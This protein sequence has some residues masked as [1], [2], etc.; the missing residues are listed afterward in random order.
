MEI[1]WLEAFVAVAEELHFGRAAAR[2][3]LAQSPLSQTIRKLEKELGTTLFDRSTRSVALTPAGH[4]FLPH[5]HRVFEELELARQAT[6][7]TDGVVYGT[8][9]IGFSGALNHLTL[10]PL[11]RAVRQRYPDVTLSLTGRVMTRDGVEALEQGGLDIAFVGLPIGPSR[12]RTR[13]IGREPLGAVLPIDHPLA[14]EAGI[15]LAGLAQDGF[16]TTPAEAGSALQELAM[17]ACVKAGFRPRIVQEITDPYMI[18]TLVS[19]GVG[20]ALMSS[21]ISGIL[22]SGAVF[23]PLRGEQT[24]LEHALAWLEDNPSPVLHAVLDVAAE[25]LP[26]P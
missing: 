12:V 24:Y 25:V 9:S 8:V 7:A 22:P 14:N 15:D 5:A 20:V 23:V 10:P 2:L 6:R 19:A 21:G 4:A 16:I 1:R 17:Q 26:T 3:R 13:M 18:L 11:T